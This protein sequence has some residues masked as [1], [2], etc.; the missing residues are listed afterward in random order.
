MSIVTILVFCGC[1]CIIVGS[2][3]LFS[4]STDTQ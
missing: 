2:T 3:L 1:L 4:R